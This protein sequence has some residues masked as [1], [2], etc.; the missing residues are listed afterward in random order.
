MDILHRLIQQPN[1]QHEPLII[2]ISCKLSTNQIRLDVQQLFFRGNLE[3]K[4]LFQ[5]GTTMD[6]GV[7]RLVNDTLVFIPIGGKPVHFVV[8][9]AEIASDHASSVE[10][11]PILS[12]V[13]KPTNLK[14]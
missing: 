10:S 9:A 6:L 13:E 14:Y 11:S 2:D 1:S 4:L 5:Q 8:L 3:D 12:Q 7:V